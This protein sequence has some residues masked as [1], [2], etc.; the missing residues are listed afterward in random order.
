MLDEKTFKLLEEADWG[1]IGKELL[2]FAAN[3]SRK[4]PSLGY[5]ED[6]RFLV[7]GVSYEDVIQDVVAKAFSGTRKWD[8]DKVELVP[9]LKMHIKSIIDALA[10]SKAANQETTLLGR[11]E[12]NEV[13]SNLDNDS[14]FLTHQDS[15]VQMATSPEDIMLR[16]EKIEQDIQFIYDAVKGD[17]ELELI[18]MA[19]QCGCSPQPRFLAEELNLPIDD[20]YQQVRRLR[21]RVNRLRA[22]NERT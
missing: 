17:E 22:K 1:R 18:V 2:A 14:S 7:L 9:W 4:Y 3:W 15:N 16:K 11:C 8:P 10:K 20:V 12:E 19:I 21:R 13:G 5:G 6:P